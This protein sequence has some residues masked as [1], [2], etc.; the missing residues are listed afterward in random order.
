MVFL[1]KMKW[2]GIPKLEGNR[3][4]EERVLYSADA[5][6]SDILDLTN[7]IIFRLSYV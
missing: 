1:G 2:H 6:F 3:I 7:R 4:G 5:W